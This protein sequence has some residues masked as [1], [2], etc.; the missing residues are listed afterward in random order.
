MSENMLV[1]SIQS[2]DYNGIGPSAVL[3]WKEWENK[4]YSG[5]W[6]KT[7]PSASKFL[8]LFM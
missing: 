8:I 3:Q 2:R 7:D 1:V 4:V 5:G 6:Q